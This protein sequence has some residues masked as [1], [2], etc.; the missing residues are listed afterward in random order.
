MPTLLVHVVATHV[1]AG[2]IWTVQLVHYPLFAGVG[3]AGRPPYAQEHSR[4]ITWVVAPAMLVEAGTAVLLVRRPP[5]GVPGWA[6]WTGLALVGVA[7]L[8]T[9][10]PQ[11]PE[12]R[13]MRHAFDAAAHRRLVLT[14]WVRGLVGP[15]G[16][17]AVHGRR[18]V[19]SRRRPVSWDARARPRPW[20][21]ACTG[22]LVRPRPR[23]DGGSAVPP[24]AWDGLHVDRLAN[25][26]TETTAL[27]TEVVDR[28]HLTLEHRDLRRAGHEIGDPDAVEHAG[29]LHRGAG[30]VRWPAGPDAGPPGSPRGAIRAPRGGHPTPKSVEP[31][32]VHRSRGV[33]PCP[34]RPPG[35]GHLPRGRAR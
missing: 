6:T 3:A 25:L 12:H 7:W 28:L 22:A 2:V 8:S 1:M 20:A 27:G 31:A 33:P 16:A 24:A 10:L 29:S 23:R 4:R 17:R 14:N 5:D 19:L 21:G 13:R 11:V 15:R 32:S 30:A 35:R 9:W 34:A 26:L 18:G